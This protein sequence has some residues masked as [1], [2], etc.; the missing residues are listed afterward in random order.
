MIHAVRNPLDVAVSMYDYA[1][2]FNKAARNLTLNEFVATSNIPK[3][4]AAYIH[5]CKNVAKMIHIDYE[6]TRSAPGEAHQL[7]IRQLSWSGHW[8]RSDV[9]S[10]GAVSYQG[11]RLGGWDMLND[12]TLRSY[13]NKS[14]S[15]GWYKR[16]PCERGGIANDGHKCMASI[17]YIHN[18][19][20]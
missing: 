17:N 12:V 15:V 16:C 3:Q 1:K 4:W 9:P 11:G 20:L 10:A 8:N 14:M 2:G 6:L 5:N 7:L 13:L 19:T 18:N